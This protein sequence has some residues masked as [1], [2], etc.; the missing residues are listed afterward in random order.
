MSINDNALQLLRAGR[1]RI[2]QGWCQESWAK[3][4]DGNDTDPWRLNAVSW[5]ASG[6]ICAERVPAPCSGYWEAR[7][8]LKNVLD[9]QWNTN[10]L[11]DWNDTKGR[12]RKEVLEVYDRA[13]DRQMLICEGGTT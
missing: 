3:D 7:A 11:P 5:C 1:R 9:S 4:A 13:I 10:L 6:A 8:M 2:E 12:T